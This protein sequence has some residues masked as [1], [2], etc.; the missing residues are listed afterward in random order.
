[1]FVIEL[2]NVISNS[3]SRYQVDLT[4]S[5]VS[6]NSSSFGIDATEIVTESRIVQWHYNIYRAESEIKRPGQMPFF[7]LDKIY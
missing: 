4:G 3:R 7:H 2:S 1:M 6:F 5:V